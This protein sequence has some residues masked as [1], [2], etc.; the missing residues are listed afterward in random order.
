MIEMMI[1][2]ETLDTARTA[3]VPQVGYAFWDNESGVI[4]GRY[5][6]NLNIQ[7]Q[8]D[9]GRTISAST[10]MWWFAQGDAARRGVFADAD[11]QRHL[12]SDV[13]STLAGHIRLH[14]PKAFWSKGAFD[15]EIL[16]D[17]GFSG[18]KFYER[19]DLRTALHFCPEAK[20]LPRGDVAH[21]GLDDALHQ[22][23]QLEYVRKHTS[24]P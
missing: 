17:L 16:E 24:K 12:P 1:D 5:C 11:D 18:W 6:L 15:F 23:V 14:K 4:L 19:R 9:A 22:I 20:D 8:I 2:I 10:L 3:V 21:T 7:A 13:C